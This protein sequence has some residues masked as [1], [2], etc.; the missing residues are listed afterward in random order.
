[1]GTIQ[2]HK[3]RSIIQNDGEIEDVYHLIQAVVEM[4]GASGVLLYNKK[5]TVQAKRK[6]VSYS[7]TA[8]R[9]TSS[10]KTKYWAI[11][12]QQKNKLNVAEMRML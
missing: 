5:C 11:K 12:R 10:Y 9:P 4:E 3:S 8:I 1:M 7:C 2:Y 6:F